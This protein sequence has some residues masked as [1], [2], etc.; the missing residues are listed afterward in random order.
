MAS[1]QTHASL[2]M[3][4]TDT[5]VGKTTLTAALIVA[6]QKR[7]VI[8][9]V[10]KPIETGVDPTHLDESDTERL[11]HLLSPPPSFNSV[12]LYSFRQ[13]LAPLAAAREKNITI[14]FDKIVSYTQSL[15]G[16]SSF[17]FIEG[18]GGVLVPIT[19]QHTMKDLIAELQ[20]PCLIVGKTSLGGINHCLLTLEVLQQNGIPICGIV[21]N[22]NTPAEVGGA[23]EPQ[24]TSTVQLIRERSSI[25]VFGPMSFETTLNR[26]WREGIEK[27]AEH[28]EVQRLATH[29]LQMH[30]EIG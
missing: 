18:A 5:G 2:F 27:L 7:G 21:L 13:A 9:Q 16:S 25:P 20:V 4:G 15:M 28:S 12:C 22:K 23:E 3:T 11:R 8:V 19:R 6:F 10:V 24:Q 17:L 29:L 26:N 30:E 14:D 1:S